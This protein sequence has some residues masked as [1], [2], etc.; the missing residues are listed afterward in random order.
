MNPPP[1]VDATQKRTSENSG[2]EQRS[3]LLAFLQ[4]NAML[5]LRRVLHKQK[6]PKQ[7]TGWCLR[8]M[9]TA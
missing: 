6:T 2:A 5:C 3:S 7:A 4:K 9:R 8:Y 1:I